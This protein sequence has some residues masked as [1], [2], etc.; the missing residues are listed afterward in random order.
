MPGRG[1]PRSPVFLQC[2]AAGAVFMLLAWLTGSWSRQQIRLVEGDLAT[3]ARLNRVDY[4]LENSALTRQQR[5]LARRNAPRIYDVDRSYLEALRAAIEGLPQAAAG[6]QAVRDV[7]EELVR[8]FSLD[9]G[10]LLALQRH[11]DKEGPTDS[12]KRWTERFVSALQ[13]R[14][15]VVTR[16][17][18]Q[19]FATAAGREVILEA[20]PDGS[21]IRTQPV[22]RAAVELPDAD[23]GSFRTRI[24]TE[25]VEAGFPPDAAG[26][27]AAYL[28]NAPQPTLRCNEAATLLRAEAASAAVRPVLESHPRG[29]VIFMPGDP[30]TPERMQR[31][32]EEVAQTLARTPALDRWTQSLGLLGL[33]AILT[34]SIFAALWLFRPLLLQEP[35]KVALL[36]GGLL[37]LSLF[38][39]GASASFE[40]FAV[41]LAVS[42]ALLAGSTVALLYDRRT[43]AVAACAQAALLTLALDA[44]EGFLL[45]LLLSA[46]SGVVLLRDIRN[47]SSMIRATLATAFVAAAAFLALGLLETPLWRGGAWQILA[48]AVLAGVGAT[49]AGVILLVLLPTLERLFGVV[50]G[51]TL[52]E[53]RDPRQPLLRQLQQKAPGTWTHSLQVANLAE[54]GAEAIG[55]DGLLAYVGALYHDV[56][57]MNKPSYFVENQVN[58]ENRHEKLRPA[59]SHLVIVG[60]VKDGVELACEY[61]LPRAIRHFI[62]SHHGTTLVEYFFHEA[63]RRAER[64]G[65]DSE[66][67][68]APW[69]YPGPRPQTREAAILMLAD[70]SE[71]ATRALHEPTPARIEQ[72]V[73]TISRRRLEDGQFDECPMTFREL[74]AVEDSLAKSLCALYH[75]RISY[76][77]TDDA[78]RRPELPGEVP[79]TQPA[80]PALHRSAG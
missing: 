67:D 37:A 71:S 42:S 72:V 15:P 13:V 11:Q 29:E 25:A 63:Q 56:G 62:E 78:S 41:L 70:A 40:R 69:R 58:G 39:A 8:A 36:L 17:E 44:D 10:A 50:T 61:R 5:E 57:K 38:T 60:H 49:V 51:L 16:E 55:A 54:A 33:Y 73:R 1:F 32:D 24:F 48:A 76:P 66:L 28:A 2:L 12:W 46:A 27:V 75:G 9:Q 80:L 68:D 74:R 6:K 14:S 7:Q 43:G 52:A 53:L 65:D 20:G 31:V 77:S 18:F 19:K 4:Q 59:M 26:V 47:R 23:R 35:G 64:E 45:A 79:A 3:E 30:L 34:G 22:G 21:P